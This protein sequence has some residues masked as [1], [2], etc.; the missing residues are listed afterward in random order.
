MLV[1]CNK[2][3]GNNI[4]FLYIDEEYIDGEIDEKELLLST[5]DDYQSLI[6]KYNLELKIDK[7]DFDKYDYLVI[8][9]YNFCDSEQ[10]INMITYYDNTL[11]ILYNIH[12]MCGLCAPHTNLYFY[13]I[14]KLNGLIKIKNK[15]KKIKD[16]ECDPNVAYKPILY[17]YP[18]NNMFINIK[19]DHDNNII[20]SYP[21]YNDGWN[22]FVNESGNI[23]YENREY[24]AL[25]WDEYNF[26]RVDFNTGFYVE[27]EDAINFLEEKLDI[28][29]L[30]NREA[31]E[32]IMYWLPVLE[33]NE[34]SLVYFE[35]TDEREENNKLI[36]YPKPDS[37]LRI[38]M[39]VKK[40]NNKIDIK[41]E[42]LEKFNR[43]G[44]T[45]VEW[46]GTIHKEG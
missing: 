6:N 12:K 28:I 42:K 27:G 13:R 18:E 21:K 41:E 1:G 45:V 44:Y 37:M 38:N 4:K 10:E 40:V 34:H 5:Y 30:T 24:Y 7:D 9:D 17:I 11:E 22:V 2:Q 19:L 31:N 39:H 46:G 15:Y 14:D 23:F 16:E 35:L 36:I 20:T 8:F 3:H 25:Y 43:F 32:F 33:E 26:N 29:G